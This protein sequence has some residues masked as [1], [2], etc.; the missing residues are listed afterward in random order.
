MK[1]SLLSEDKGPAD[2]NYDNISKEMW[3]EKISEAQKESNITFDTEN[4]EPIS[5]RSITIP[6]KFWEHATCR[7]KC[8]LRSAGGDWQH[9]IYY[10]RCQLSDG[11]AEGLS[12]YSN[13]Q[14]CVI[15][16]K[17]D[18]NPHLATTKSGFTA[19]NNSDVS[20]TDVAEKSEPNSWKFLKR[21][22]K[23]LVDAEIRDVKN[24]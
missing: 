20:T 17:K 23:Q 1:L 13:S 7:F 21:H 19:P 16:G 3:R 10:F 18:G 12:K 15:P 4:D 6:Q 11:H 2:F 5:N 14:F 22:L 24:S 8:E 9:Q